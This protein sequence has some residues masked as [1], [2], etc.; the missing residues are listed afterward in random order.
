ME[1]SLKTDFAQISLAAQKLCVAQPQVSSNDGSLEPSPTAECHLAGYQDPQK[2]MNIIGEQDSLSSGFLPPMSRNIHEK[3]SD[4][5]NFRQADHMAK[6][7]QLSKSNSFNKGGGGVGAGWFCE[8]VDD[9][10]WHPVDSPDVQHDSVAGRAKRIDFVLHVLRD[11]P[12][13]A[14]I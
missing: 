8:A 12:W 13:L 3:I 11:D 14:T 2:T 7:S 4:R 10:I 9:S 1:T 6:E 5:L